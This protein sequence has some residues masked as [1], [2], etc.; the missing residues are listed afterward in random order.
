MTDSRPADPVPYRRERFEVLLPADRLYSP[1]HFWL[2]QDAEG[3]WRVGFT[4]FAVRLLGEPVECAVTA[5]TGSPVGVGQVVGWVEGFK[6]VTELY[7]VV[8][9]TLVGGNPGLEGDVTL[10]RQ[11]PFGRGWLYRAAGTPA[12]D[13]TDARGY[14]GELDRTIDRMS[15][16]PPPEAGAGA[17]GGADP[18][19]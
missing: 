18:C 1:S 10:L 7:A 11:D 8:E 12:A 15:A 9:G 19:V 6:A 3:A 5:A 14:A 16:A 17:A 2:Q 13:C 4:P